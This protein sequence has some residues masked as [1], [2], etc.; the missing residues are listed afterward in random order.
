MIHARSD[1]N[2]IQAWPTKREHYA[3]VNGEKRTVTDDDLALDHHLEPIIPEDE[4]V[5]LIRGQDIAAIPTAY[6]W[7]G[8]ARAAGADEALC[9]AVEAH[10]DLI[11]AWQQQHAVKLPDAPATAL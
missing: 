8:A 11:R 1:Y 5:L 7:L 9:Q 6:A 10:I 2:A 4:P 3:V